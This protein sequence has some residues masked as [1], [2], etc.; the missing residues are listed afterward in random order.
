MFVQAM[1]ARD[2]PLLMGILMMGFL[3]VFPLGMRSVEK[4]ERL[5][6][7]SSIAQDQLERLK[8]LP[9]TDPDL[10][11]GTHVDPTNPIDGVYTLT[12]VVTDD[13]PMA[14]MKTIAMAVAYSDNGVPRTIQFRTYLSP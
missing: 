1:F 8:M 7:A 11:A 4:G 5:T 9:R 3:T 6:V 13:A 14:E 12:W 2:Y 10:S